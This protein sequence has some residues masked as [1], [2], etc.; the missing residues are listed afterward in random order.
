LH[1]CACRCRLGSQIGAEQ[2]KVRHL[3]ALLREARSSPGER[4]PQ[5]SQRAP[6]VDLVVDE[7]RLGGAQIR[8]I[9][10]EGSG[11]SQKTPWSQKKV[12]LKPLPGGVW[13]RPC[14]RP[15]ATTGATPPLLRHTQGARPKTAPPA[16]R[17]E[18]R[19]DPRPHGSGTRATGAALG[20]PP[21]RDKDAAR[22]DGSRFH[23][24]LLRGTERRRL[25]HLSVGS[26][27]SLPDWDGSGFSSNRC[28]HQRHVR[29]ARGHVRASHLLQHDG[30]LGRRAGLG[31]SLHG[32]W[33]RLSP[34]LWSALR[35]GQ[36]NSEAQHGTGCGS[37]HRLKG[38]P[39]SQI[40]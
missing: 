8:Q 15:P 17:Q 29:W 24:P 30:H 25:G 18:R 36:L 4:G 26:N 10:R 1:L 28:Q 40:G 23:A 33:C 22:R 9:L 31:N 35:E 19:R 7:R 11:A 5:G 34:P 6:D 27:K 2:P 21:R 12:C 37:R 3:G 39:G 20:A 14:R 32:D 16:H 13:G 38:L